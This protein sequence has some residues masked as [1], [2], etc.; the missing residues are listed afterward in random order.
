MEI[1]QINSKMAT[2]TLNKTESKKEE[3]FNSEPVLEIDNVNI[4]SEAL[5]LFNEGGGHPDRP[6]K[7]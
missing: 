7:P 5:A 2:H 3:K 1:N 4:S 6:I